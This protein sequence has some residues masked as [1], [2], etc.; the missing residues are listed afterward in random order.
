M[1]LLNEEES[2]LYHCKAST[3]LETNSHGIKARERSI[4]WDQ[5]AQEIWSYY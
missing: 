5:G 3:D 2:A 1:L 4:L